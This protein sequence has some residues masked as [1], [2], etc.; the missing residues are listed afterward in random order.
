MRFESMYYVV[1]RMKENKCRGSWNIE[2]EVLKVYG[3]V[4]GNYLGIYR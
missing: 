4:L 1:K 3:I 2:L